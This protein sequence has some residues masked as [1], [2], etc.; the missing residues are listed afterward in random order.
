MVEIA[1]ERF[2]KLYGKEI[3]PSLFLVIGDTPKDIW[4]AHENN[5]AAVG[6]ATG[7]FNVELLQTIA[8]GTLA[9]FTNIEHTVEMFGTA[10][11]LSRASYD[12]DILP[13]K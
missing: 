11:R 12:Y 13:T 9:D 3:S 8:D 7:I 10:Q 2:N 6:V 4:C 5:V 1:L